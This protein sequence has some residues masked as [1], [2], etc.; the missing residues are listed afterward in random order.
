M[1]RR[2]KKKSSVSTVRRENAISRPRGADGRF[3]TREEIAGLR[4]DDA[5]QTPTQ[6]VETPIAAPSVGSIDAA[7]ED[8][9]ANGDAHVETSRGMSALELSL[10]RK[11]RKL[12]R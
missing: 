12:R 2:K 9:I 8:L 7:M 11:E 5:S 4:E 10:A 6:E 1:A 3:L